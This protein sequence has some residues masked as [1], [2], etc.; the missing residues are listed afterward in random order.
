MGQKVAQASYIAF[1]VFQAPHIHKL[2]CVH[3]EKFISHNVIHSKNVLALYIN[4]K[5][6]AG[7]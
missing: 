6:G 3:S 4:L 5:L 1:T 2:Q 7:N